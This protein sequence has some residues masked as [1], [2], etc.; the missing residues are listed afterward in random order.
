MYRLLSVVAIITTGLAAGLFATAAAAELIATPSLI[1]PRL[2]I[3]PVPVRLGVLRFLTTDDD[4]PFNFVAPDGS[5]AGFNVDFARALCQQVKAACTIQA[6][7]ADLLSDSLASG[8]GDALIPAPPGAD[9]AFLRSLPYF[10][11]AARFAIRR[12]GP[13]LPEASSAALKGRTVGTVA[14]SPYATYLARYFPD[15]RQQTFPSLAAL[16]EALGK[17]S[18]DLVFADAADLAFWLN[19][20]AAAGCC[21]FVPGAFLDA[22]LFGA[23]LTIA[24]RPGDDE[25]RRAIDSAL[26]QLDASGT[27]TELYLRYFPVPVF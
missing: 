18:I 25:L 5:L 2:R 24:T 21:A 26:T 3:D 27:V 8:A 7:R 1:N 16:L 19:G 10:P 13:P 11:R 17:G 22:G 9:P 15:A 4:P 12:A 23:G 6:R 20:V 14:D